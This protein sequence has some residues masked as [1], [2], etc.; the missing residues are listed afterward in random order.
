MP[1]NRVS[2]FLAMCIHCASPGFSL[3]ASGWGR[4]GDMAGYPATVGFCRQLN[5]IENI[6]HVLIFSSVSKLNLKTK[7]LRESWWLSTESFLPSANLNRPVKK[8]LSHRCHDSKRS[9][10]PWSQTVG[11]GEKLHGMLPCWSRGK[12]AKGRERHC[13]WGPIFL[14]AFKAELLMWDPDDVQLTAF[15]PLSR[16][17]FSPS[18]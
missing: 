11:G 6:L 2:L 3:P 10:V 13:L 7:V 5:G 15:P 16:C 9:P 4:A 18:L 1:T 12:A 17:L 14:N 8:I